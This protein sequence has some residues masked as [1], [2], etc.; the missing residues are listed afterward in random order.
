MPER[1]TRR[2]SWD[3]PYTLIVCVLPSEASEQWETRVASLGA[4]R[5]FA[6][7]EVV[8]HIYSDVSR[9]FATSFC[10]CAPWLVMLLGAPPPRCPSYFITHKARSHPSHATGKRRHATAKRDPQGGRMLHVLGE[11]V[12]GEE[13]TGL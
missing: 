1:L 5:A 13:V 8:S 9:G 2:S 11:K 4:D 10:D 3:A 6:A 12:P 7:V